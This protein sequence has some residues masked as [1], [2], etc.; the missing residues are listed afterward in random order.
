MEEQ[1]LTSFCIPQA[2]DEHIVRPRLQEKLRNAAT[3]RLVVV[4]APAAYGKTVL[5]A[6]FA[7]Q[8]PRPTAWY[9]AEPADADVKTFL[10]R[11]FSSL[12]T[13]FS[14][15]PIPRLL[16][17]PA[18]QNAHSL[19]VRLVN[20]LN[21]RKSGLVLVWDD[22]HHLSGNSDIIAAVDQFIAHLPDDCTLILGSRTVPNLPSL[23]RL[24][25]Y[26]DASLLS[27]EEL[28]LTQQETLQLLN[29]VRG[30]VPPALVRHLHEKARGWLGG[31]LALAMNPDQ[32]SITPGSEDALRYFA[33]SALAPFL[34]ARERP[35]FRATS[36]LTYLRPQTC[37]ALLDIQ[38][39]EMI[40]KKAY[41]RTGFLSRIDA[42]PAVYRWHDLI[43][44][45]MESQFRLEDYPTYVAVAKKAAGILY[46]QGDSEQAAGLYLKAA[47]YKE[48][49]QVLVREGDAY[50]RAG[51]WRLLESWLNQLPQ[52]VLDDQPRLLELQ[53][54][55]AT[56]LGQK[57]QAIVHFNQALEAASG[58]EH[59]KVR[60][61]I[62]IMRSAAFRLTGYAVE[63][64]T[65]AQDAIA[66]FEQSPGSERDLMRA[67]RQLAM[68]YLYHGRYSEAEKWLLRA[69]EVLRKHPDEYEGA[70]LNAG[71]GWARLEL[72]QT[73]NARSYLEKAIHGWRRMGN[74][75]ELAVSLNNLA[76]LLHRH[77]DLEQAR[78]L[79]QEGLQCAQESGY[80]RLEAVIQVGL[81]DLERDEGD[82]DEA[83]ERYQKGLRVAGQVSEANLITYT[84]AVMGDTYRLKSEM[85]KSELLLSQAKSLAETQNQLYESALTAMYLAMLE[86]TKGNFDQ[87]WS[88]LHKASE[89]LQDRGNAHAYAMLAL[90]SAE[91]A[92]FARDIKAAK[93]HLE[94]LW[95]RCNALGYSGFLTVES[96]RAPALFAWAA[97]TNIGNGF[98]HQFSR[99]PEPHDTGQHTALIRGRLSLHLRA[100]AFG[101]P[102]VFLGDELIS[103]EMWQSAKAR[104]L[105]FYLLA[106]PGPATKQKVMVDLWPDAS[107]AS[108]NNNFHTSMYRLRSAIHPAAVV[109]D[110]NG[111]LVNPELQTWFD[112]K[113]FFDRVRLAEGLPR[114]TR[115]RVEALEQALQLCDG[116]LF[117]DFYSE[118]AETMKRQVDTLHLSTL[119]TLA[120]FYTAQKDFARALALL[121]RAAQLSQ[122]EENI[123]VEMMRCHIARGDASSAVQIYDHYK[124]LVENELGVQ[125][126][127]ALRTLKNEALMRL[128][129]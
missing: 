101:K 44:E 77:G 70:L 33:D 23:Q 110:D 47:A 67:L 30:E 103:S 8:S 20:R 75:A 61:Q 102:R 107:V 29:A 128:A 41:T 66:V 56:R 52:E 93:G 129:R 34:Q 36:V 37:N 27:S 19:V 10:H 17:S 96:L 58:H 5:L 76:L 9:S 109:F 100:Y 48:L 71:M 97:T 85:T 68:V 124:E 13:V 92:F 32:Q 50:I 111:Y 55:L 49:S 118:W 112:L 24:L 62:L 127:L 38:D 35:F 63:A 121:E 28:S 46:A 116:A 39:S 21:D 2:R 105:L 51:K 74:Q 31:I 86:A 79:L 115:Q 89:S 64:E 7:R 45:G 16:Q 14:D 88:Y 83:L 98:F 22:F 113:E 60:A 84:T 99:V 43:R 40:L 123:T 57:E 122:W 4:A 90:Y 91:V 81:G 42:E 18:D 6:Q 94:N 15:F 120:G 80:A 65:D 12:A 69:L 82:F 72:G 126:S 104:E 26:R 119:S 106:N 117:E 73:G 11:V 108:A 95:Q 25:T 87:S 54:R 1:F 59:D 78:A 114:G 125:P 3:K 53:G